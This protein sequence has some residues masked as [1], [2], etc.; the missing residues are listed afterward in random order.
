MRRLREAAEATRVAQR[1][2]QL[3]RTEREAREAAEQPKTKHS[4][5]FEREP[6]ASLDPWWELDRVQERARLDHTLERGNTGPEQAVDDGLELG[7]DD[8]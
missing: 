2:A 6:Y 3:A 4:D 8:W 7:D 1:Y 5:P